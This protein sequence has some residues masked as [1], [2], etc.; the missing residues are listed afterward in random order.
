MK[1]TFILRNKSDAF[2]NGGI[3][4]PGL[5]NLNDFEKYLYLTWSMHNLGDITQKVGNESFRDRVDFNTLFKSGNFKIEYKLEPRRGY[6][7]ATFNFNK[8]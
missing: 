8:I 5:N 7:L 3:Y 6:K 1:T 2:Y 4:S